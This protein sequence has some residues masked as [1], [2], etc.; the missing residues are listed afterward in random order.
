MKECWQQRTKTNFA[1]LVGPLRVK[2]ETKRC[3]GCGRVWA[4]KIGSKNDMHKRNAMLTLLVLGLAALAT[5]AQASTDI[6]GVIADVGGYWTAGLSAL[7]IPVILWVVGK[8]IFK[9]STG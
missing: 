4:Q 9:K 3:L 2:A 5:S 8:R 6:S 7:G 1:S